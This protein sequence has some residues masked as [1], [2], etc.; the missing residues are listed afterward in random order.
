M[1][2]YDVL[3]IGADGMLGASL[4]IA[5]QELGLSYCGTSRRS[6]SENSFVYLDLLDERYIDTKLPETRGVF[7]CAAAVGFDACR[8][9]PTGSRLIN[10]ERTLKL[11]ALLASRGSKIIFPSSS[12]VLGSSN[13]ERG[14]QAKTAPESEYAQMKADVESELLSRYPEA[15]V[16][17]LTKIIPRAFPLFQRWS[18]LLRKGECIEPFTNVRIAPISV[19]YAAEMMIWIASHISSG[20]VHIS[21]CDDITYAECA[22]KLAFQMGVSEHLIKAKES[23]P[24]E[25]AYQPIHAAL[26]TSLLPLPLP[27]AWDGVAVA[28]QTAATS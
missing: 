20:I 25:V 11:L 16:V 9:D 21:S 14:E 7:F 28:L 2:S 6:G 8:A 19:T 24:G 4:V 22:R 26:E 5:C 15:V 27:T 3:I 10:V 18:E 23:K 13:L 17:R 1:N 12:A